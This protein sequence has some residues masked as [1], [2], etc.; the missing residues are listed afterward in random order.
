MGADMP[1]EIRNRTDP[2]F[3]AVGYV[4]DL[5]ERFEAL[6]LTVAPL[7]FGAG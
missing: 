2:G 4:P 7:R 5:T 1:D 6:R 3:V